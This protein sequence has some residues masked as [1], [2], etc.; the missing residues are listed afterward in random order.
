MNEARSPQTVDL[1]DAEFALFQK[2]IYEWAGIHMPDSKKALVSSRIM[3]RL[4]HYGF[5]TYTE[6]LRLVRSAEQAG[7]KQM[8][9]NLLTTNE[10]YFFREP[11]HFDWLRERAA[12]HDR[13]DAF[14]V[15]SA[16]CSTGQEAYS[17]AMVLS[18]TLGERAWQVMGSD[19]SERAL[20]QAL[21]ASYPIEQ[22]N[23]IPQ[24][25]LKKYCLRG[26]GAEQGKFCITPQILKNV[27]FHLLNL[28]AHSPGAFGSFDVVFLRNVMI[29]FDRETRKKVAELLAQSLKPGGYI[30]IGHA[31]SLHGIT[32]RLVAVRPTIYATRPG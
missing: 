28:L 22:A 30:V 29:Y 24:P 15:W 6:Y 11:Q 13:P 26:T 9:I 4:R 21:G 8:M 16:A 18:E 32:D 19:I 20:S 3:K 5:G 1:T 7:E 17:V 27:R 2:L 12:A 10:T 14:R 31:E 23:E 25:Y